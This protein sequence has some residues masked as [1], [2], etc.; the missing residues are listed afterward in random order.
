MENKIIWAGLWQEMFLSVMHQRPVNA[1]MNHPCLRQDIQGSDDRTWASRIFLHLLDAIQYCFGE[2]R[3]PATY[4]RLVS[5]L[6]TWM[7]SKPDYFR[8]IFFRRDDTGAGFP[9]I[10]LLN[11]AVVS[12]LQWY[13]LVRVLLLAHNPRLPQFGAAKRS[14]KRTRDVRVQSSFSK[15]AA[16]RVPRP[17]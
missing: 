2:E 13:H 15:M 7:E 11:S 9:E 1:D 16:N 4:D 8:P 17:K 6:A 5:Y 3:S 14:A 10:W 12:G